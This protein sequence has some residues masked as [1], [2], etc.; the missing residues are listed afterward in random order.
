MPFLRYAW[1]PNFHFSFRDNLSKGVIRVGFSAHFIFFPK[2]MVVEKTKE[3]NDC[4]LEGNLKTNDS[5]TGTNFKR[6]N[7]CSC[8]KNEMGVKMIFTYP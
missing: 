1:W 3:T 6:L 8:G 7:Y 2:Q 4:R 5:Q